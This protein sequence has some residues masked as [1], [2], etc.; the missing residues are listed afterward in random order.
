MSSCSVPPPL[1]DAA[2]GDLFK[3]FIQE[4]LGVPVAPASPS[5]ASFSL[6]VAFGRCRSR[7]DVSFV[8]SCLSSVL[9]GPASSFH[10]S[11]FEDRIFFFLVSNKRVGLEIYKIK[12]FSCAEFEVFFHL[13]N[14]NGLSRARSHSSSVPSF[15]WVEVRSKSFAQAVKRSANL[16]TG[17]NSILLILP[18]VNWL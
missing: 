16:L 4:S 11:Q 3:A 17:A 18:E 15:P 7:L 13:F 1:K 14:E 8:A 12:S 9:G 6:L 10:A 2:K 5:A